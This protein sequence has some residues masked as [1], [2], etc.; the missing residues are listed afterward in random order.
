MA[1]IPKGIQRIELDGEYDISRKDEIVALF[2]MLD[3]ED[4]LL[5]NLTAVSYID[6]T[7]LRELAGLRLR[8]A[9]RPITLLGANDGIKRV[10]RIVSFDKMFEIA[11]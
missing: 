8:S 6:S 9:S 5:I 11:E 10:F 1:E 7:V 3:G 2:A 4:P